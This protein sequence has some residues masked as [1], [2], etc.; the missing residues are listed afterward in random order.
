MRVDDVVDFSALGRKE[1]TCHAVGVF[2]SELSAHCV[3]VLAPVF[4]IF[5]FLTVQNIDGTLPTHHGYLRGWPGHV[6]VGP[7]ML[8]AHDNV[9]PAVRLAR[10]DGDER[11]GCLGVGIQELRTAANDS[12]PLLVCSRQIS[13]NIDERDDGEAERVTKA[14]KSGSLLARFNVERSRHFLRL[15]GNN[16][17]RL[18]FDAG[19]PHKNVGREQGVYLKEGTFIHRVFNDVAHVVGL[20]R[21]VGDDDV[22]FAVAIVGRF[23]CHRRVVGVFGQVVL[24]EI[25]QH[26]ADVVERIRFIVREVM[27]H[28]RLL[29]VR[30]SASQLFHPN[31]FAGHGAND[32]RSRH[33]HLTRLVDHDNEV[34]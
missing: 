13:G 10:D 1:R 15:V 8:R 7:E 9:G 21:T 17:D 23:F 31:L 33:E 24:R 25:R 5:E 11:N 34:G 18:T 26:G 20:V 6:D 27:R 2:V 12:L 29:R 28:T 3:D 16:P 30:A 32:I 14:D 22:E 19:E 4:R